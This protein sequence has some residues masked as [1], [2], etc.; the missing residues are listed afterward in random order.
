MLACLISA[1]GATRL[2]TPP[3]GGS[4]GG[5]SDQPEGDLPEGQR[6]SDPDQRIGQ[7]LVEIAAHATRIADQVQRVDEFEVRHARSRA[8]ARE[9]LTRARALP[10]LAGVRND[11]L[12]STRCFKQTG[13]LI[14]VNAGGAA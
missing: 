4:F 7:G 8:E 6:P 1:A 12:F 13:A 9:V 5:R 11:V 3:S 2:R 10:E 14:S